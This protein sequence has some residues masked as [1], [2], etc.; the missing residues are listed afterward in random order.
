MKENPDHWNY[1]HY[2]M[3]L[4]SRKPAPLATLEN[5]DP[6]MG[7]FVDFKPNSA[8]SAGTNVF[9]SGYW[10][11]GR[12]MKIDIDDFKVKIFTVEDCEYG[13]VH[14][15]SK[16]LLRPSMLFIGGTEVNYMNNDYDFSVFV[17]NF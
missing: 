10:R 2:P 8:L 17:F 12:V 1:D 6:N 5:F 3:E 14:L 7:D 4:F 16:Y 13:K 15:F 11:K 9:L